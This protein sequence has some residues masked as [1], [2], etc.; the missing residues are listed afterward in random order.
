M[1]VDLKLIDRYVVLDKWLASWN[2]TS[3]LQIVYANYKM[4][5]IES[6]VSGKAVARD[7]MHIW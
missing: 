1:G 2:M 4:C 7:L 5:S 3:Q 6:T